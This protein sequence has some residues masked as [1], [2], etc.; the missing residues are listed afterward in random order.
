MRILI[1]QRGDD[2]FFGREQ[3]EYFYGF[4]LWAVFTWGIAPWGSLLRSLLLLLRK[5]LAVTVFIVSF[6]C[7]LLTT[8][9]NFVLSNGAEIMGGIGAIIFSAAIFVIALLL[10]VYARTMRARGVLR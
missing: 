4:P 10:I 6:G 9:Q 1:R 8:I 2:I 3:L 7:L 5:S